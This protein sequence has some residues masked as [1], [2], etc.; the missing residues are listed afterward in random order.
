MI[1]LKIL[2]QEAGIQP[3]YILLSRFWFF[4]LRQIPDY[5]AYSIYRVYGTD[6][7]ETS[8]AAQHSVSDI[9]AA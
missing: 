2:L 8:Y 1:E 5:D 7:I 4:V 9:G 3:R 6:M